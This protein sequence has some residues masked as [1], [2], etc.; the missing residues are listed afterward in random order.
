MFSNCLILSSVIIR[1]CTFAVLSSCN[2]NL[3][4]YGTLTMLKSRPNLL[5]FS[6]RISLAVRSPVNLSGPSAIG[7][8]NR[9]FAGL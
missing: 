4:E 7:L 6:I 8:K 3:N 1:I 9:F 5:T 2:S